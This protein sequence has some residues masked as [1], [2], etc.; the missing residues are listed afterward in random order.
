MNTTPFSYLSAVTTAARCLPSGL[1]CTTDR[2]RSLWTNSR[3][4]VTSSAGLAVGSRSANQRGVLGTGFCV[5]ASP[6]IDKT[7]GK[8][9]D[10][11]FNSL[12]ISGLGGPELLGIWLETWRRENVGL[13]CLAGLWEDLTREETFEAGL[14]LAACDDEDTRFAGTNFR[15]QELQMPSRKVLN[16][17][18]R[19]ITVVLM[20]TV[21]TWWIWLDHIPVSP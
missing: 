3:T 12:G 18:W 6:G 11:F 13:V 15:L 16:S 19:D 5:T 14:G 10:M 17:P 2:T 4:N 7:D 1:N 20:I 21:M 8:I 9:W